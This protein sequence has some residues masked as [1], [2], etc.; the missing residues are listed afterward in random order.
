MSFSHNGFGCWFY[1]LN[2]KGG[3]KSWVEGK[4]KDL[5]KLSEIYPMHYL[6]DVW[7]ETLP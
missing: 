3:R 2:G 1:Y 7:R 5:H 6:R 4:I